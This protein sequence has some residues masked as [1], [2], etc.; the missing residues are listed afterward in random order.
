MRAETRPRQRRGK[1]ATSSFNVSAI[2][3]NT[4]EAD[5]NDNLARTATAA[6]SR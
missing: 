5:R 3:F 2:V 1:V 6:A 4:T